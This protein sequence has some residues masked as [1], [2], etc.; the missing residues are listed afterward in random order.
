MARKEVLRIDEY[1]R[2]V[3][4]PVIPHGL[5]EESKFSSI[6]TWHLFGGGSIGQLV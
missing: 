5:L 4:H 1:W 2:V 6:A 3:E